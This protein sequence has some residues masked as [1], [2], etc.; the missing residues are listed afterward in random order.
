MSGIIYDKLD[1]LF[2]TI[3]LI[4]VSRNYNE[5]KSETVRAID[6][7]GLDGEK[8]Y[9]T[10]M[11]VHETYVQE[12]AHHYKPGKDDALFFD[13]CSSGLLLLLM[14]MFMENREHVS[15]VDRFK[16]N[17]INTEIIELCCGLH[18]IKPPK[19]LNGVESIMSFIDACP[20]TESEKWKLLQIMKSPKM[21]FKQLTDSISANTAAFEKAQNKVRT[22][23][24]KLIAQYTETV[25]D[26][27]KELFG[28]L[29][30]SLNETADV[31]PSLALPISQIMFSNSCYYG[32]LSTTL[33]KQQGPDQ[34]LLL[35]CLKAL[36][37]NSRL[38]ILKSV[39]VKPKYNLEIAEQLGLT[40]ATMSHHMGVLLT[41]GFVGVD[42]QESKVY[43]HLDEDAVLQFIE[44]LKQTLI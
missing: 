17:E 7:L 4:C 10:Q 12:F 35:R 18:E 32:L 6:E 30:K 27:E 21:H 9:V 39:K 19:R 24:K 29:R 37:D 41:C 31:Y 42:K 20:F 38:E 23:L 43:Y 5:T 34:E 2:E 13:G 11:S 14:C 36:S 28:K 15:S 3:A 44:T 1:P 26:G 16:D 25:K 8:F 40:A 22:S 33:V